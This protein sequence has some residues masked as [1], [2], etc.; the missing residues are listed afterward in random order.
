MPEVY[1]GIASNVDPESRLP[2]ALA[3]LSRRFGGVARSPAF[4]G[5]AV[6]G[7]GADYW[8]M[9]AR[10]STELD[11]RAIVAELKAIETACGRTRAAAERCE[12]D[13]D[14]LLYGRRVDGALG[15]PHPDVLRRPFVL[16]PLALLAPGL[17]HP[18][19]GERLSRVSNGESAELV[20][21]EI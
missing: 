10:C 13:L 6:D 12:M 7:P 20:A 5:P 14:L 18:V 11:A 3:E 17:V 21:V 15:L 2:K 9:A 16:K 8:N 1:V 4:R 19:T